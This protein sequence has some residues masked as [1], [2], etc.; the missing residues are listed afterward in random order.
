MSETVMSLA[1]IV[2]ALWCIVKF[3]P[4]ILGILAVMF[5]IC[6]IAERAEGR[7]GG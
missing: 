6:V 2:F 1:L 7:K 4:W 3:M 5:L